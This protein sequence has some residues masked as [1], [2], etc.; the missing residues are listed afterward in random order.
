LE[1]Q[2]RKIRTK[3]KNEKLEQKRK[4]KNEQKAP[5]WDPN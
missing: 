3:T 5:K 1:N 4:T 2:K